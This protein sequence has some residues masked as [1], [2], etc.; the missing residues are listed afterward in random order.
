MR[1]LIAF[2]II[3]IIPNPKN[4]QVW[5][6]LTYPKTTTTLASTVTVTL[7]NIIH[8]IIWFVPVLK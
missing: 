4:N 8:N 6:G 7:L 3:I 5:K 1:V 2:H